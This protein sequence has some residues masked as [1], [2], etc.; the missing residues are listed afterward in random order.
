MIENTVTFHNTEE[1]LNAERESLCSS[2]VKKT[3]SSFVRV[4][5][6]SDNTPIFFN[7]ES[8]GKIVLINNR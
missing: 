1:K 8:V 4:H 5:S 6:K 3:G 7:R 2:V